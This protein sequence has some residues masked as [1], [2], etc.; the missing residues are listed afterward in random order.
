MI[1]GELIS[2]GTAI[3]WTITVVGFEVAGKRV[4]SIA[5]NVIRLF[6]GL[7]L[8]TLTVFILTGSVYALDAG[9][10]AW[11]LLLISG[12]VGLVIGDLFLFQAFVD[13]GGRLSL[14]ILCSVP[15]MTSIMGYYIFDE[16]LD[17]LTIIGIGITLISIVVVVLSKRVKGKPYEPNIVKGLIFAFIGAI[18]QS[19]GLVLSKLGMGESLDAI[20]A[21]HIRVI[22]AA[23]GF[24]IFVI[25]KNQWSNLW[26]ALKDRKAMKFIILGSI[27]GPF[28]GVTSSLLAMR[29]TSIGVAT[30]IAQLNVILIIP[31]SVYLFKEKVNLIEIIA[32]ISAFI[33]V[34]ILFL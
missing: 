18:A 12:L 15:I 3:F 11:N 4:G 26:R 10:Y 25:I 19:V 30:T 22:G 13:L 32:S 21:T 17:V 5:V 6:I 24:I 1:L 9:Q 29:Y 33:G 31:F 34:A 28:L 14:L 7:F 20:Q 2:L 16:S 27:F 23:I 8:L